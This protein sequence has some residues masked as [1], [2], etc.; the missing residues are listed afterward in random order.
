MTRHS[1]CNRPIRRDLV[2]GLADIA[3]SGGIA[4]QVGDSFNVPY[5]DV[6][7]VSF[8]RLPIQRTT[9]TGWMHPKYDDDRVMAIWLKDT[10]Q[11]GPTKR[12]S[13]AAEID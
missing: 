12:L 11:C 13:A 5:D 7:H 3:V 10:R 1:S 2:V 4:F 6:A 9:Q 8:N